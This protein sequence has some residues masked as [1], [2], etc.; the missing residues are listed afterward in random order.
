MKAIVIYYSQT[1]NTEKIARAIHRGIISSLG[2]CDMAWVGDMAPG[3]L[4]GY[5][6][7]GL[8]TPVWM[9]GFTPN[10]R[11]FLEGLPDQEGR[12]IF[13]FNTHGVLPELYFPIVVRMLKAKGFMVIGTRDWF[14]SVHLQLAPKPYFT[15]GHPDEIDI[16]EA[17]DFGREMTETSR[18]ISAGET[19]LIPPVPEMEYTPQ[20]FT[21]LEFFQSGHNP[22]GRLKYDRG[23]CIYPRCSLCMD[24]CLMGYID[25]SKEPRKFGSKG[26]ECDMWM[27]CTF[28]ELICPTGAIS[29]DW[30]KLMAEISGPPELSGVNPLEKA[31]EDLE[32]R[33]ILR[34]LASRKIKGP[35][36]RVYDKH[37][38]FKLPGFI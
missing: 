14:G 35:Y 30:D 25:L 4:S 11:I 26:D 29:C 21:L 19:G 23:K 34:R 33:G 16:R 9:G 7:I 15:D 18:R 10:V 20:L 36:F 12:H 37:P 24:N 1:G 32:K 27:G 5:D 6:L 2:E 13:S 3:D 38:R 8:G 17:E 31:A 22:N 28:C